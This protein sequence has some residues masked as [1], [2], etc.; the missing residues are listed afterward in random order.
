MKDKIRILG[1]LTMTM[2]F[3]VAYAGDIKLPVGWAAC[4]TDNDC[5]T[6]S[7]HCGPSLG[8]RVE[9]VSETQAKICEVEDCSSIVCDASTWTTAYAVC[10]DKACK[11]DYSR[12][13]GAK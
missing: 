11:P 10:K 3:G 9:R 8:V 7:F 12:R 4:E 1:L 13:D 5:T 2:A 6:V